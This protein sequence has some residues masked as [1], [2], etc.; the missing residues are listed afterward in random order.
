MKNIQHKE[1]IPKKKLS[2]KGERVRNWNPYAAEFGIRL[3]KKKIQH[4]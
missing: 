2:K 1:R 4:H 3:E